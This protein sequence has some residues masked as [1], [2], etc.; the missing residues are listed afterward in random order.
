MLK[1]NTATEAN[2]L[3]LYLQREL[4][5]LVRKI[6]EEHYYPKDFLCS[7]GEKGYYTSKSLM[8]K[9]V[10]L[11]EFQL[12]EEVSKVCMTTG[13]VL[14]CHLAALTYVR[15]SRNDY[16]TTKLLPKLEDGTLLAGTGLSNPMKFY[17]DIERLHLKAERKD[18]GYIV[19]GALPSVSNIADE[20]WFGAVAEVNDDQRIMLFIPCNTDGLLLKENKGYMGINGSA[21]YGCRFHNCFIP[22]EWVISEDA[23]TFVEKIRPIFLLYQIP[24]GLG[25]TSASVQSIEKAGNRQ[26]GCN[27]YLPVQAEELESELR[28]QREDI[29]SYLESNFEN[30]RWQPLIQFRL[31]ITYLTLKAANA[32]MIH[33]GGAGYLNVS[34]PV[35]RLRETYF[36]A[37][38][39]PTV[40]H[41]EKMLANPENGN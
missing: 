1:E 26:A 8:K 35:R 17:A 25:V 10:S 19:S 9:D 16:L 37:N 22:D 39:T 15:N 12:V 32:S 3:P 36:L 33:N 5:P 20:H 41:L 31:D 27:Q 13:F 34:R 6:D 29:Y 40:K 14:W 38:L 30:L 24:M 11:R 23:D 21:T 28:C 18:G 7:L 4:K 2:E